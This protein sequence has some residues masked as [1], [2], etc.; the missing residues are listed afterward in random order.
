MAGVVGVA[1]MVDKARAHNRDTLGQYLYGNDSGLDQRVLDFLDITAETL[2]QLVSEKDDLEVDQWL[3]ERVKR[4]SQEIE[5]FNQSEL[6]RLPIDNRHRQLL[7]ERLAKYAPNRT[8]I[9]T[10]LQSMEL[11]DWGHFWQ[12]DLQALPPRSPYNRE[13]AGMFGLARMADKARATKCG[14]NGDYKYGQSSAFDQ[15][16]LQVL[17][18]N[19]DQFQQ[20]ACANP[21][22]KELSGKV[23]SKTSIDDQKIAVCNQ[24]ARTFGLQ[25]ESESDVI[26]R[27]YQSHFYRENFE[28]RRSVVAPNNE[29]VENWL[30]L[31]DYDDQ[32]SFGIMDLARRPPRSPYSQ[33]VLGVAHLARL[34][35]T[36]RAC[37]SGTL[38]DYQYG[39]DSAIDRHALAFLA[40]KVDEFTVKLEQLSSDQ[41]VAIGSR[42]G[43]AKLTVRLL[44]LT[45]RFWRWG[46]L[47]MV[48]G[49][50]SGG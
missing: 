14:K 13:V 27:P 6:S 3:S 10:V 49:H 31:M 41:Q 24:Q 21:N 26:K 43:Q 23:L 2:A 8:D 36:G 47:T 9:K 18:L 4:S 40:I 46:P 33:A 7:K 11:D 16:F 34:I 17:G 48:N 28:Y 25:A 44:S 38:G 32:Q 30:D 22:D 29:Q 37:I 42:T 15:Y 39:S 45:A 20:F 12:V 50:L 19:Q 35:D 1:R 5:D